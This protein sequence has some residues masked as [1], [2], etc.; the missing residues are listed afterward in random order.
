MGYGTGKGGL[1]NFTRSVAMELAEFGIRVNSLT[2]TA[3]DP[4]E[5]TERAARWGAQW[6]GPRLGQR[7]RGMLPDSSKGVPMQKLPSP[8]HYARAAAFLASDDADM[9]TGLD[10]RIDAGAISRYWL[11][12]PGASN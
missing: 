7:R 1:L 10:L 5:G 11:W 8:S 4:T 3:T 12:D 2:P 9:I 6:P